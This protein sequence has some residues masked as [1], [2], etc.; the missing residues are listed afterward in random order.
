MEG[1]QSLL[2]PGG[3]AESLQMAVVTSLHW[4]H[5]VRLEHGSALSAFH[6]E[7]C[8]NPRRNTSL[9]QLLLL[10]SPGRNNLVSWG[11]EEALGWTWAGSIYHCMLRSLQQ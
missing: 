9:E 10:L 5:A 2:S 8:T 11:K 7:G 6:K 1:V 4:G 3:T